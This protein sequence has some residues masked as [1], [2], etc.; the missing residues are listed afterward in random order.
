[1]SIKIREQDLSQFSHDK[2]TAHSYSNSGVE[3]LVSQGVSNNKL[4]R[5]GSEISSFGLFR[6]ADRNPE[7][8][9][10]VV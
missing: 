10:R 7:L 6:G 5:Q 3:S 2:K 8:H 9:D 1:M 4:P